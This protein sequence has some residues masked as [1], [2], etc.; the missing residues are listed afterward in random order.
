M[1]RPAALLGALGAV[2][3]LVGGILPLDGRADAS[4]R[5]AATD[6]ESRPDPVISLVSQDFAVPVGGVW[7]ARYEIIGDAGTD[8]LMR[9]DEGLQV[10]VNRPGEGDLLELIDPLADFEIVLTSYVPVTDRDDIP[11]VL[12]GL[13]G[14]ALDGARLP[15]APLL[16]QGEQ[17]SA[18]IDLEVVTTVEG[19]RLTELEFPEAGVYPVTMDLRFRDTLVARHLT[20]V[21]RLPAVDDP[22][23]PVDPYLL[24]VVT[25]VDDPGGR[26][27]ELDLVALRSALL[28]IAEIAEA[29]AIPITLGLPPGVAAVLDDDPDLRQR[30]VTALRGDEVVAVPAV[31]ID[32]SAAVEAGQIEAFTRQL[33][34]G[35]NDL[36]GQL[37]GLATRRGV[38]IQRRPISLDG[39]VMLRDLG[40]QTILVPADLYETLLDEPSAAH[41]SSLLDPVVLPDGSTM[42]VVTVDPV[43]RLLDADQAGL[44]TPAER[45]V[46]LLAELSAGRRRLDGAAPLAVLSTADLGRPDA[47]VLAQLESMV[48]AHPGLGFD[49]LTVAA[50]SAASASASAIGLPD[51]AG[52]SL[53]ERSQGID[54]ARLRA[55]T[56]GSML[57]AGDGRP[58][59]WESRLDRLLST[60]LTDA[61]VTVAVEEFVDEIDAI[62]AA[63][64]FPD[65]FTFTLTGRTSDIELRIT[66]DSDTPL[67]TRLVPRSSKL[68]F[69]LGAMDVVLEPG[70]NI[71]D[72]P[73]QTRSNGTFPVTFALRT[74]T[75]EVTIGEPLELTARVN[76]VTG[77][78]QLI[79]VG[80]LLVLVSWWFSHL[81]SRRR[82]RDLEVDAGV[83]VH[84]AGRST[85]ARS[86]DDVTSTV[87]DA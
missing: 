74:P 75:G 48:A 51:R 18:I 69:P 40:T 11:A 87:G 35:E 86:A 27:T 52:T 22:N 46:I 9:L 1:R 23:R 66:N 58:A 50:S 55:A 42:S 80:A 8:I 4:H 39:A 68:D 37:P 57:P 16:R 41:D 54:L 44:R 25:A 3:L 84:P 72:V 26:P 81:R 85:P 21:E 36:A 15:I 12:A 60:D 19:D 33:R 43:S 77:L 24:A 65:P 83:A 82:R 20:F 59:D 56:I 61:E 47:D 32:P 76:A 34:A 73:V 49:Q 71:I 6:D 64:S 17:G 14:N 31:D 10:L 79:T 67:A 2:V 70:M 13:T 30:L 62:P 63:I 78:G 28:E 5:P 29:T 53:V 7:R 45:A 38:T